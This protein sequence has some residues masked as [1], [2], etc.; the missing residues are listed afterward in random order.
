MAWLAF[1]LAM[2]WWV[3]LRQETSFRLAARLNAQ[4]T[5]RSVREAERAALIRRIR[6]AESR[7]VLVPRAESLGLRFP[8]DSEIVFLP[9]PDTEHP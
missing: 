5:Q 2:L 1:V 4:R 9:M 8:Q 3:S 7:A 6:E